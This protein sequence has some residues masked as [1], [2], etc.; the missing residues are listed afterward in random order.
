MYVKCQKSACFLLDCTSEFFG[1][2][3][4]VVTFSSFPYKYYRI[5]YYIKINLPSNHFSKI[6]KDKAIILCKKCI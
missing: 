6:H 3:Y 1:Q 5:S 2:N 4:R